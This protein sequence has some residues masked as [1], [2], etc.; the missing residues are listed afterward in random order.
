MT[1]IPTYLKAFGI[2]FG[3]IR[4]DLAGSKSPVPTQGRCSASLAGLR[5]TYR[6]RSNG[7]PEEDLRGVFPTTTNLDGIQ[8]PHHIAPAPVIRARKGIGGER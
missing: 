8:V 2:D 6:F 4:A 3:H 7:G 1:D 5:G